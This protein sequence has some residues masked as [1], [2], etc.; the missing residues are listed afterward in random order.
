MMMEIES[1]P[2]LSFYT[3]GKL[4]T[5]HYGRNMVRPNWKNK[6]IVTMAN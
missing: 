2:S 3:R 5:T 6:S 4:E 1:D